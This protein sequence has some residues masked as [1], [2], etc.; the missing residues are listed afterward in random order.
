[1]CL[2]LVAFRSSRRCKFR[3]RRKGG[4][5]RTFRLFLVRRKKLLHQIEQLLL[6]VEHI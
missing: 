5:K 3:A 6:S 4:C 2:A 1:M